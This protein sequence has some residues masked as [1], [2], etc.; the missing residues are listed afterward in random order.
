[1]HSCSS[2]VE[3]CHLFLLPALLLLLCTQCCAFNFSCVTSLRARTCLRSYSATSSRPGSRGTLPASLPTTV[4]Y[5]LAASLLSFASDTHIP[6]FAALRS[7]G[8][9]ANAV[10][11]DLSTLKVLHCFCVHRLAHLCSSRAPFQLDS[12]QFIGGYDGRR[13]TTSTLREFGNL[14]MSEIMPHFLRPK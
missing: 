14:E 5:V 13:R 2:F 7:P 11:L 4:W 9:A 1:M 12:M 8:R 3:G 6:E 10:V